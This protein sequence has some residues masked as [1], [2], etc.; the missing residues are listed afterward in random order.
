MKRPHTV[1]IFR[2][3]VIKVR[4]QIPDAAIGVDT[5]IGF[6][7]ETDAAFSNTYDLINELPITYLHVF[8]F[9]ARPGTPAARYPDKVASDVIKKRCKKMRRLGQ[10]KRLHFHRNF[11]G[12]EVEILVESTRH[13]ATGLLKGVSSNYLP[14]LIDADDDQ[15]NK[16]V[17]VKLT[18]QIDNALT[19]CIV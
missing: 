18:D 17:T 8:P 7:G 4:D 12:N 6:P 9:S 10:A 11:I 3:R 16:F 14:V 19:G 13:A 1:D 2:Q 5:L 15:I